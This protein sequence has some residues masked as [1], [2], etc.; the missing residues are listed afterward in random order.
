MTATQTEDR[1]DCRKFTRSTYTWF[2]F[3]FHKPLTSFSV[4]CVEKSYAKKC[5][6]LFKKYVN[7]KKNAVKNNFKFGNTMFSVQDIKSFI[8]QKVFLVMHS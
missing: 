4:Q 7:T 6:I 2:H 3:G 5:K 1:L 8:F